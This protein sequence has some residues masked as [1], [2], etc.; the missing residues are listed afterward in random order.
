MGGSRGALGCFGL[1]GQLHEYLDLNGFD[2]LG[3]V[4]KHQWFFLVQKIVFLGRGLSLGF[5]S[6]LIS[7]GIVDC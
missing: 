7:G 4:R 2:T 5:G 3:L 6:E 1:V